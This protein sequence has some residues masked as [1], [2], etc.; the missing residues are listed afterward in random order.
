MKRMVSVL[1]SVLMLCTVLPL[2]ACGDLANDKVL[3]LGFDAE[4]PPYGYLDTATQEYT[5]FDIELARA[6]CEKIGY[7]LE[8]KP[9]AWDFKDSY[10]ESGEINCIW[11]GFT[12]NGR[13]NDY[14]WSPAYSDSSIVV[15]VKGDSIQSLSD[16]AGKVVKVQADSSG[17][18]ALNE[19]DATTGTK[20]PSALARTF[21][22]GTYETCADYTSAFVELDS[23]AVDAL[24]IDVG[25]AQKLIQGR[26]GFAILSEKVATE[27]YAIGFKLGDT[28]L[29]DAIWEGIQQLD[30]STIRA[31]AEKYGI[32]DSITIDD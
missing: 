21:K 14:T 30:K 2:A 24:V 3:R 11:N 8:L 19:A 31:L 23:G 17:E 20:S 22:N 10:L 6:V 26:T 13:E 15:L 16:L 29:R 7:K 12:M 32:A 9:I 18:A 5:G 25:V 1:L 28:A 4:F 27:Q